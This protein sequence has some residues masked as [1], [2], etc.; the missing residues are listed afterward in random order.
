MNRNNIKTFAQQVGGMGHAFCPATFKH[1]E[2]IRGNFAQMQFIATCF[3]EGTSFDDVK[4]RADLY[5]LPILFAYE[6]PASVD[7]DKLNI[8]FLNNKSIPNPRVAEAM[9]HSIETIF[10]GVDRSTSRDVSNMFLGGNKLIYFDESIPEIGIS[11]LFRNMTICLKDRYGLTHY[12]RKIKEFSRLHGI[13]LN[14]KKL[15]DVSAVEDIV[16]MH[17][18][19]L[20]GKNSPNT[21]IYSSDH[22]E[23][24]PNK[25]DI[26]NRNN[27]QTNSIGGNK[28]SR[29]RKPFRSE[30]INKIRSNCQLFQ[31]FE[32][33]SRTLDKVE[34]FGLATNL[35]QIESGSTLFI[36]ILK[37]YLYFDNF[38]MKYAH[39]DHRLYDLNASGLAPHNRNHCADFC[40][41]KDQCSHGEN[42]ISTCITKRKQMEKLTGQD[43]AYV[44]TKDAELDFLNALIRALQSVGN[45]VYAIKAQ[46]GIGKTETILKLIKA[47]SQEK[48]SFKILLAVPLLALKTEICARAKKMQIKMAESPSLHEL[49]GILPEEV[50]DHIKNL[51]KSGKS[52]IPFIKMLIAKNDESCAGILTQYIE[53]LEAFNNCKHHAITTHQRLVNMDVSKYDLVIID[54]D[55]IL[56]CVIQN[57][58]D[59]SASD[60]KKLQ[61][62]IGKIAPLSA[63]IAK[64]RKVYKYVKIHEYFTLPKIHYDRTNDDDTPMGVDIPSFC[65]A[66]HF[67]YKDGSSRDDDQQGD[68]IKED[69]ISFLKPT[70][71]RNNIKNT[72][73][74]MVSATI[75]EKICNYYFGEDKVD[76]Y[77]C[78]MA[79][80]VGTLYQDPSRPMSRSDIAKDPSIYDAIKK[81]TGFLYTISF[82]KYRDYFFRHGDLTFGATSGCDKLKG[83][84]INVV[85]TYHQPEWLYKLVAHSFGLSFDAEAKIKPCVVEYNG[86]RF[87]FMTFEDEVLRDIQFYMIGSETEQAVGRAR[88]LRERCTVNLISNFPAR[89][90]IMRKL[91]LNDDTKMAG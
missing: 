62:K 73:V 76:F 80:Y 12:H 65:S 66:T 2:R 56:N 46:T 10:P 55:I 50:W 91:E 22:G 54:E 48:P 87:L 21:S 51:Y 15:I 32:A 75:D 57:K 29:S 81:V 79:A 58:I 40:P 86:Y 33:G 7:Q 60:V 6:M 16:D 69:C 88:L 31:E 90:A 52:P 13:G 61:K 41:H 1:G 24:L 63:I 53:E 25:S 59:I 72:K 11:E 8:V 30:D 27:H 68:A 78:K 47:I 19:Y 3:D 83:Q 49:E 14:A 37:R 23:E 35:V 28:K 20:N 5:D 82:K 74:I 17:N 70:D 34:L 64:M 45:M 18:E 44:S 85:G 43:I 39:W 4:A 42:I 77:E 9:L 26:I 38:P 84:N 89:Q 36:D 71:F 67:C